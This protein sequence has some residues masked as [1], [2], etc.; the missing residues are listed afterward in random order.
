MDFESIL[1]NIQSAFDCCL[2][3][4]TDEDA[5]AQLQK[6]LEDTETYV[7]EIYNQRCMYYS[8]LE[9]IKDL[10][11]CNDNA[12]AKNIVEIIDDEL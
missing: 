9:A 11:V 5:K 7:T 2:L 8:K 12:L 1:Y 10:V 3:V 4:E 6:D